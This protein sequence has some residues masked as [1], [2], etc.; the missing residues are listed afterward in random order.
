[1]WPE[2]PIYGQV[3]KPYRWALCPIPSLTLEEVFPTT[4]LTVIYSWVKGIF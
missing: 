1:M 4:S 3:W 2:F